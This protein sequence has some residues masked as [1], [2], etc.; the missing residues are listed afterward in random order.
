VETKELNC[1]K[2]GAPLKMTYGAQVVTCE[3]CGTA[4]TVSAGSEWK[5]IQKHTLLENKTDPSKALETAKAWMRGGMITGLLHRD[6]PEKAQIGEIKARYVPYWIIPC[7]AE[8]S[9]TGRKGAG[10][11]I[12]QAARQAGG[13]LAGALGGI[14]GGA[15]AGGKERSISNKIARAYNQPVVAVRG[16]SQYELEDYEFTTQLKQLFDPNKL[17]KDIEVLNGDVS[18]QEAIERAKGIISKKHEAEAKK[19]VDVL[20]STYTEAKA[21][22]GELLHAPI[23]FVHYFY[24]N[25]EYFILIDGSTSKVIKGGRPATTIKIGVP[26]MGA[27][28]TPP[29]PTPPPHA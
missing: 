28:Q 15:V 10:A 1:Q 21:Q 16:L 14:L 23:W 3:Y 26:S 20:D 13:G 27:S 5:Q 18:E 6:L 2:C 17:Q 19:S 9:Y 29:A 12:E 25:N 22:E 8:T 24:E 7:Y 11:V 4:M